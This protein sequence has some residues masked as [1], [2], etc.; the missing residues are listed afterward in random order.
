MKNALLAF[1]LCFSIIKTSGQNSLTLYP[2]P[3][4]LPA[5]VVGK[6][7]TVLVNNQE[8]FVYRTEATGTMDYGSVFPEYTYFDFE[9]Y[10]DIT[11]TPNYTV[12]TAEILPSRAGI[13]A[14]V[15][16]NE[17]SFRITEPGQYFVKINGNII[18]GNTSTKNLY[19]F[20]N[21]PEVDVPDEGDPDVVYFAP[22]TYRNQI[23]NLESNKTYYIAGGAFVDGQFVG[24]NVDNVTIRGRGI[25][26]GRYAGNSNW[27]R[28]I[29]F[30][31]S[32][33]IKIEGVN[34]MHPQYWTVD[35]YQSNNAHVDNI[36]TISHG[37]SSEGI[38]ITACHNVLVENSFF[39]GHDDILAVKAKDF[40][41]TTPANEEQSC[42]DVTFRNVVV[43]C[44]ASNP[45]TI[46]YET[47]HDIKNIRYEEI[48]VINMSRPEVW[49]I[50]AIMA[51]EPHNEGNVDSIFY[52]D[53]RV[54]VEVPQNSLFRFS[55]DGGNGSI[56]NVF[57][58]DI[59][60]NY[61]GTLGGLIYGNN[62]ANVTNINFE[63]VRNNVG[64]YLNENNITT[65]QQ[66]TNIN[67]SPTEQGTPP[68]VEVYD[69]STE[70]S[71]FSDTQ[72]RFNW[73]YAYET[74]GIISELPWNSYEKRWKLGTYCYIG[75][76]R[77]DGDP[78][79]RSFPQMSANMHPEGNNKPVLTWQA[80]KSGTVLIT[81]KVRQKGTCGD[82][83][84]V[85]IRKNDEE[86][87]WE[88]TI[89]TS[90]RDFNDLGVIKIEV[91]ENDKV[92]FVVDKRANQDCDNTELVPVI[93]L[94]TDDNYVETANLSV[95][96]QSLTFEDDKSFDIL[97]AIITPSNASVPKII[98]TS[99]N[100]EV[101]TVNEFGEVTATGNGQ[102]SI[103]ASVNDGTNERTAYCTVTVDRFSTGLNQ[104][105]QINNN[106]VLLYPNPATNSLTVKTIDSTK[107]ITHIGIFD[108]AGNQVLIKD[109]GKFNSNSVVIDISSLPMGI[110]LCKLNS[111]SS[112]A[113]LKFVKS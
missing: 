48:D 18:N 80:P 56:S 86:P 39:R 12:H 68:K 113:Y 82:R 96:P 49:Q 35:I 62:K 58:K 88:K 16:D 37:M 9:G 69:F 53:I 84:D 98:W 65:D 1:F 27:G 21:P 57:L 3:K 60:V 109:F 79:Y 105:I 55:V 78:Y 10:V 70:F 66:V 104:P 38:D 41:N 2:A 67:V 29:V 43:W 44:E 6:N 89:S 11:V 99:S 63:N 50:E 33:N 61:E 85:S 17:I 24:K 22:G 13:N 108:I 54:D 5:E 30:Q 52:E 47:T 7:Y 34:V 103:S 36:H 32:S 42:E 81:G 20:A 107:K 92:R 28:A 75:W 95:F 111:T 40:N 101:A 72:G 26:C 76:A 90:N 73:Y 15:E 110:Y 91:N 31:N 97:N 77:T 87:V 83:V 8:S 23:Y 45:M 102:C 25:I 112:T 51:I 19:I 64:T 46:G 59:W 94:Y 93:T 74:N 100:E 106:F 71:G 14:T 4:G